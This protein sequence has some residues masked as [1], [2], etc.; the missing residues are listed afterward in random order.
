MNNAEFSTEF[1]V[2]Y[3]N[4]TS[5]QAPGLTEFEKSVFATKAEKEIVKN[6][7]SPQSAG[8]TLKEG[9]DESAKRQADF[10]M[11]MKTSSCTQ[12]TSFTDGKSANCIRIIC[13]IRRI[14]FL[15]SITFRAEKHIVISYTLVILC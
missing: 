9:F 8:N 7:F 6:Y 12:Q 5:N 15:P 11:L 10:S 13:I 3:N 14:S 1:D 2:L 4:I